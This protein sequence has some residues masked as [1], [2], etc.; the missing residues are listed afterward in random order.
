MAKPLQDISYHSL[1]GAARLCALPSL[2][3]YPPGF[4]AAKQH[5][6]WLRRGLLCTHKAVHRDSK[7]I[8]NLLGL[9]Y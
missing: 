2:S 5:Y 7:V 3:L 6:V 9:L 4:A 8:G 1:C